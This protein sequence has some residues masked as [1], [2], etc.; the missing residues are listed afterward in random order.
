MALWPALAKAETHALL[1]GVGDYLVL[2]A[3]L[4]GPPADV[5]LLAEVLAGRG[6]GDIRKLVTGGEAP[7]RAAILGAMAEVGAKAVAGDMVIF[8]FS[9]HGAQAPDANGDEGG[10]L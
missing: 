3:D 9:G 10:G 5:A 4:K 2:D 7:T 1:I 8:Y 6:V